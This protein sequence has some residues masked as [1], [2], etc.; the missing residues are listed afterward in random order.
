MALRELVQSRLG[1]RVRLVTV[2]RPQELR[3]EGGTLGDAAVTELDHVRDREEADHVHQQLKSESCGQPGIKTPVQT[4]LEGSKLPSV[5]PQPELTFDPAHGVDDDGGL[6]ALGAATPQEL[7]GFQVA[8]QV[9]L[10]G[11][12]AVVDHVL[13]RALMRERRT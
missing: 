2:R 9:R 10:A 6:S 11:R 12:L 8:V 1:R 5:P 7:Q 13:W 3:R 4:P